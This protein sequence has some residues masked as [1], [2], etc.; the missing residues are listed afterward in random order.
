MTFVY[1]VDF[2]EDFAQGYGKF[3]GPSK[4]H[5]STRRSQFQCVGWI[6]S[7]VDRVIEYSRDASIEIFA[8]GYGIDG[9]IEVGKLPNEVAYAL[10]W[11]NSWEARFNLVWPALDEKQKQIALKMN[12]SKHENFWPYFDEVTKEA[13]TK[14]IFDRYREELCKPRECKVERERTYYAMIKPDKDISLVRNL[15]TARHNK[16]FYHCFGEVDNSIAS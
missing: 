14:S 10:P 8:D 6:L 11:A 7:C 9:L 1:S 15:G 13:D 3:S 2:H 5:G 4:E 16:D 12:Y